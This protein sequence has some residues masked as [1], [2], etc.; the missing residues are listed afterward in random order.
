MMKLL[1]WCLPVVAAF[2]V[3]RASAARKKPVIV[4][5]DCSVYLEKMGTLKQ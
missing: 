1:K 3:G 2:F 5:K 4:Y